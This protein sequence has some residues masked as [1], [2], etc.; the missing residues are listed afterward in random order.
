MIYEK[1]KILQDVQYQNR[2]NHLQR[3]S[4]EERISNECKRSIDLGDKYRD[5]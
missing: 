3:Q 4:Y 2:E 5:Q 1:E